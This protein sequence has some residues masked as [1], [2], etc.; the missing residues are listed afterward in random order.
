MLLTGHGDQYG[1]DV[2]RL[3]QALAGPERLRAAG[4]QPLPD[5]LAVEAIRLDHQHTFHG[6]F[7]P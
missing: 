7:A 6:W 4:P 2:H 1:I 3:L 5:Q